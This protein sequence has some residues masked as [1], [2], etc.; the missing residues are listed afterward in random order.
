MR[1]SGASG[2]EEVAAVVSGALEK[3]GVEAVLTGGACASLWSGGRYSSLDLDFVVTAPA[4]RR[5]QSDALASVGFVREGD[6]YVH[7]LVRFW[8]EFPRGPL[9]IGSDLSVRPVDIVLGRRRV[10]GLSATD[11]CRD[12]L[13]AFYFWSDRQSL[14]V[15]VWIAQRN[16]VD[17]KGIRAWSRA[18]GH[19]AAYEEFLGTLRRAKTAA[20]GDRLTR[21]GPDGRR[22]VRSAVRR[23][24]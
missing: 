5:A 19:E 23:P 17:L 1:L 18:E 22:G 14:E 12:R 20:A 13:A 2:L 4:S 15:A 6:R 24:R 3:H 8:V 11:S 9:A 21:G 7:P 10:R 16:G